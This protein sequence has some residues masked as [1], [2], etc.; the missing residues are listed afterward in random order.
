[1]RWVLHGQGQAVCSCCSPVETHLVPAP[2]QSNA[3]PA[4][5]SRAGIIYVSDSEL[6]W[7]PVVKS[8]L[9]VSYCYWLWPCF[10]PNSAHTTPSRAHLSC[11]SS[12]RCRGE[13]QQRA[14]FCNPCLTSEWRGGVVANTPKAHQPTAICVPATSRYV[15]HMLD[16]IRLNLHPVMYN[17]SVRGGLPGPY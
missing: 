11:S 8:W 4:T 9:Q 3:S 12:L 2:L 6:G 10:V 1:M 14:P 17:E 13:T 15:D 16:F 7:E 5:V